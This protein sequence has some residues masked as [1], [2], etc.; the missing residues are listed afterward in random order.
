MRRIIVNILSAFGYK[1]VVEAEHGREGLDKLG[2]GEFK[3]II[4]DWNMPEMDGLEF[5]KEVRA[6]GSKIPIIMVTTN[7][8]KNHV[9][10]ALQAGVDDYVVKPFTMVVQRALKEKIETLAAK[11]D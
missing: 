9:I 5:V 4:S 10:A 2:Q 8:E 7:A 11:G 3:V 6:K 1:D